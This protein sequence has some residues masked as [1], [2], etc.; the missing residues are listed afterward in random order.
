MRDEVKFALHS[1]FTDS[2][3]I[4]QKM[5]CLNYD[6]QKY[7]LNQEI[8]L[9]MEDG[10]SVD[11]MRDFR[12]SEPAANKANLNERS[13]GSNGR[14][15]ALSQKSK[16]EDSAFVSLAKLKERIINRSLKNN[17]LLYRKVMK[18]DKGRKNVMI[19]ALREDNQMYEDNSNN[20]ENGIADPASSRRSI[21]KDKYLIKLVLFENKR[22]D[23]A[24]T[25]RDGGAVSAQPADRFAFSSQG[26][27]Q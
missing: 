7:E 12:D 4:V 20:Q 9:K 24:G 19:S 1:G 23:H 17:T 10:K 21:R 18:L 15:S 22:V 5:G 26:G 3:A 8:K 11:L 27:M 16:D 25:L 2:L 13:T 14:K 6:Y